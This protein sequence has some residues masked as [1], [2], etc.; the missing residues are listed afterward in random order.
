MSKMQD[1]NYMKK[2]IS[3]KEALDYLDEIT[4][5]DDEPKVIYIEP[6]E[7]E[8]GTVSGEDDGPDEEE[9]TPDNLC[10]GQLKAG[11][12]IVLASGKRIDS[13]DQITLKSDSKESECE[14]E[15]FD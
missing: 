11:C 7:T 4:S 8:D 12:E 15:E 10:A 3:L 6:P 5:D 13:I 1:S 2:K 14:F 9:A